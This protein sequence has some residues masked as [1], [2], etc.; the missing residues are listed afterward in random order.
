MLGALGGDHATQVGFEVEGLEARGAP[1]QVGLDLDHHRVV[2]LAV[3]E[4]VQLR[5]GLVAVGV[6]V[7]V[8]VVVVGRVRR[9][10]RSEGGVRR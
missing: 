2:E 1:P 10:V 9:L 8:V 5:H 6:T 4:G 7:V 3:E